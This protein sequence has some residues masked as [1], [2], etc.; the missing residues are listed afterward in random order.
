MNIKNELL[1]EHSKQQSKKIAGY[2]GHDPKRFTQLI[3]CLL[4]HEYRVSQRAAMALSHTVDRHPELLNPHL[5]RLVKN[6][7]KNIHIAVIRNTI[8]LLRGISIPDNLMGEVTD[9]C[10]GLMESNETPIA[11][12]VFAMTVLANVCEKEPDLKNE[13]ALI[14]EDQ[15]PYGSP[16][17][18]NRG[19]K[20][21]KRL[22]K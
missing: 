4:D 19:A 13:L 22:R 2:I 10:F 1:K 3:D 8:R 21:L 17:F 9:I 11:V 18:R 20:I 14:I 15:L 6:L 7:R 16:G 5:Y 12:K